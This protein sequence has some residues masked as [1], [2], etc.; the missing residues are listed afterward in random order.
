MY[1]PKKAY[2]WHRQKKVLCCPRSSFP[3]GTGEIK[4]NNRTIDNY[5]G[6]RP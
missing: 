6:P 2:L 4:I 5:F 1:T 3:G